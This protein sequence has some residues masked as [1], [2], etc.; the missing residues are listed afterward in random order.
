MSQPHL[1]RSAFLA[2]PFSSEDARLNP[3]QGD[4][5]NLLILS[6]DVLEIGTSQWESETAFGELRLTIW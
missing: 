2:L 5:E 6:N 1:H 3:R 4:S